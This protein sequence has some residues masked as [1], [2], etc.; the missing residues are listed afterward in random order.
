MTRR[1]GNPAAALITDILILLAAAVFAWLIWIYAGEGWRLYA[2]WALGGVMLL[3]LI[4]EIF[5]AV[6]FAGDR[7]R[8]S[9]KLSRQAPSMLVLL[10][11]DKAGIRFWD[12]RNKTGLIIGRSQ[13]DADVDVDLSD[14]EYFSL[15][16]DQHAALNFTAKGWILTDAGSKNG[17][18]LLRAGSYQK[19]LLAPGEP[20]LI[21]PGDCIYI[22]DETAL[23]VR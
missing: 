14:T 17:T 9:H 4:H 10:N 16:S 5:T 19:L 15:I 13:D 11:E 22:A 20:V 3:W 23:A 8:D 7:D 6:R 18:A 2:L 1:S 12:L 21:R